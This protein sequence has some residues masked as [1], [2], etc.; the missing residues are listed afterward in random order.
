MASPALVLV[1]A[2]YAAVATA[3]GEARRRREEP[4]RW[5]RVLGP[6]AV[7][8]HLGGLVA[9]ATSA[10]RSPFAN[11]GEALSF[12]AFSL[13]ALYLL[14]ES[15][16]RVATHGGS[17]YGLSA[18][19]AAVGVPDLLAAIP[20]GTAL[21]R[22]P[23]RSMHVGLA[24]LSTA[25]VLAGGLLAAG[26]L[27]AYS[28]VKR[29][30]LATGAEGPSLRGFERLARRASLLGAAL[31]APALALG[32][33][34]EVGVPA[35]MPVLLGTMGLLLAMLLVA[36]LIWWL[37]PLRGALAAWLN[38]SGACLLLLTFAVVHPLGLGTR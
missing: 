20:A 13:A 29:H 2:L 1:V 12:L 14:L 19:L 16:S 27:L 35:G 21:P 18:L 33:R 36:F 9:L 34:L 31:L 28:R 4:P 22:D 24:L 5:A 32:L 11:A 3:Y 38:L 8:A 37:R 25:A 15:T 23:L 10:G 6:L 30:R 7:A 17:F 26:Y